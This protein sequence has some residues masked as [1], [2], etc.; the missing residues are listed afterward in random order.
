MS[1]TLTPFPSPVWPTPFSLRG[2]K[3]HARSMLA[4]AAEMPTQ[5]PAEATTPIGEYLHAFIT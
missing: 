4:S 2:L 1:S 3:L 5:A